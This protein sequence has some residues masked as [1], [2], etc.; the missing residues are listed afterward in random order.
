M[1]PLPGTCFGSQNS[2]VRTLVVPQG[3]A[4]KG[5]LSISPLPDAEIK[6][7]RL[8]SGAQNC[9][10]V[11]SHPSLR[12]RNFDVLLTGCPWEVSGSLTWGYRATRMTSASPHQ[13]DVNRTPN[14]PVAVTSAAMP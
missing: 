14:R 10:G 3:R 4:T 11:Q 13:T 12:S 7:A 9:G 8:R 6:A 5:C 2:A 1:T